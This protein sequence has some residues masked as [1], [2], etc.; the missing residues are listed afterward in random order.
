MM[1]LIGT[2]HTGI[3]V[4]GAG[5]G[6]CQTID[7]RGDSHECEKLLDNRHRN[8]YLLQYIM[9][10]VLYVWYMK[11]VASIHNPKLSFGVTGWTFSVKLE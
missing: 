4:L 11:T 3:C 1:G 5:A 7:E 2:T 9:M 6:G 8:I 10:C